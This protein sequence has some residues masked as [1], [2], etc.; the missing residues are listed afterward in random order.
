MTTC[1]RRAA[2]VICLALPA[3]AP[4]PLWAQEVD[5]DEERPAAESPADHPPDGPAA[6][7]GEGEGEA[8]QPAAEAPPP[9][10]KPSKSEARDE[11]PKQLSGPSPVIH[12]APPSVAPVNQPVNI[13]AS[14]DHPQL[15]K[16]AFVLYRNAGA[17]GY[18]EVSF[19]RGSP[20]PY[21]ATI[22]AKEVKGP[23][24]DYAIEV[25]HLD[26]RRAPAF[27]SRAAPHR[28]Q[29]PEDGMDLI[30]KALEKK[31]DHRRSV[32]ASRAEYV[33]FGKS[34]ATVVSGDKVTEREVN[35]RFYRVEASYTYRPM[36]VVSEFS[37]RGG[38]VRGSAP[39]PVRE[40][41]PGQAEDE[42]FDVGLNYGAP[43]VRFRF[44]DKWHFDG[45]FLLNVTEVG[46]SVGTGA[47]LHIG[48]P[49][50][51]KLT[52]GFEAI[53]TFG[54]RFYSQIDIQAHE[55]VKIS[56]IVEVTNMP[57]ADH[58]GVRLIGEVGADVGA[59][60]S[61]AARGGYQ[62]RVFTSGGPSFG[63]MLGYAF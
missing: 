10:D 57:S 44:H 59:G 36:R 17:K 56:P 14:I 23:W 6:S 39:V 34:I 60:F 52:L 7:E 50:G 29:V 51:T 16:R 1:W 15:V 46:F 13:R 4:T 41:Q 62:A 43:S 42:R 45:S 48:D 21:V 61:L 18:Q 32:V 54:T 8:N 3:L 35:D 31:L 28:I 26:S 40:L 27:S 37:I 12:H 22:P 38:V 11:P 30:E 33:S 53:Q 47:A 24:M 19:R 63:G 58:F 2:V 55:Q 25:E 5:P 20:G 49:H 9:V